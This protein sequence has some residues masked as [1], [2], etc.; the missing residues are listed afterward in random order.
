MATNRQYMII[1]AIQVV[2]G[3]YAGDCRKLE[4]THLKHHGPC[5]LHSLFNYVIQMHKLTKSEKRC[6]LTNDTKQLSNMKMRS[7]SPLIR[8]AHSN[9]AHKA[10]CCIKL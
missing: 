7:P 3:Y 2:T 4:I 6:L 9:K 1:V 5:V 10:F 8:M